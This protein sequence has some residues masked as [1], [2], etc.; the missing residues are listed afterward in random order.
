MSSDYCKHG[1]CIRDSHDDSVDGFC[2][3]CATPDE[4]WDRAYNAGLR[5]AAAVASEEKEVDHE[6]HDVYPEEGEAIAEAILEL[7]E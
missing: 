5:R 7:I 4:V 1:T 2:R 3:Y 6:V